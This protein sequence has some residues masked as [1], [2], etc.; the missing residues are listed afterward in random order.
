V[1]GERQDPASA[2]LALRH[3][4]GHGRRLRLEGRRG[5]EQAEEIV[6]AL[7]GDLGGGPGAQLAHRDVVH[8]HLDAVAIAPGA[9]ER[10]IE[11]LVEPWHEMRT[12]G[13]AEGG[14]LRRRATDADRR[15]Q[16]NGHGP[17]RHLAEKPSAPIGCSP[18]LRWPGP[19]RRPPKRGPPE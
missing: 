19:E 13:D 2:A 17:D 7:G 10:S 14:R 18:P 1:V 15:P 5:L 16:G 6:A 3:H 9:S 8:L 12:V 4:L 11:P